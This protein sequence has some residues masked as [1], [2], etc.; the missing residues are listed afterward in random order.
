MPPRTTGAA[1][2]WFP[3]LSG[4]AVFPFHQ[5]DPRS[6][7]RGF[8]PLPPGVILLIRL[9][10][11]FLFHDGD[12]L[13]PIYFCVLIVSVELWTRQNV[14]LSRVRVRNLLYLLSPQPNWLIFPPRAFASEKLFFYNPR[15]PTVPPIF[16]L[17][18]SQREFLR[19]SLTIAFRWDLFP[20][21]VHYFLA[22]QTAPFPSLPSRVR[23]ATG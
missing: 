13:S 7:L 20:P 15:N 19:L 16:L 1:K 4:W 23:R 17:H 3:C 12:L 8:F 9:V 14:P 11:L 18:P 21:S 2:R 22:M 6:P 10:P 5:L